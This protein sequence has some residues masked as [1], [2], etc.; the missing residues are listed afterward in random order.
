MIGG[1]VRVVTMTVVSAILVSGAFLGGFATSRQ[2]SPPVPR[3][4]GGAPTD[5]KPYFPV[6]WEA[7]NYVQQD[8][9]KPN[10]DNTALVNGA[11]GGMVNALGDPHTAFVDAK[12]AAISQTDLQ[13]SFEGIG[14][15]VEMREGRLSIVAPI[16][17]SPADRVGLK[18]DD[19]ILQ[20]DDKIIQN[21][22]VTEAVSLIRGPKGTTVTLKIQRA[23]QPP[24]TVSIVRDIIRTS[25]VESRM[26]EGTTIAYVRLNDFGA[27]APEELRTALKTLLAQHPTGLILDLRQDPGGYLDA[28]VD[29]ASQFLKDGQTVLIEKSKDGTARELKAKGGGLATNIPMVLLIDKG[30]ASASEIVAGALKDYKRATLIGVRSY[31]KGSVQNVHSLSDKSELRLTIAHFFSPMNNEINEVG[32]SPDIEVKITDDD[33][34]AKRDLQLDKAIEFLRTQTGGT[35][36]LI[37]LP[38]FAEYLAVAA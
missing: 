28:A 21:M 2:V 25:F 14:A 20:V 1:I 13:G 26:I 11:V 24:F 27:T 16:K 23:K 33:V 10:I 38:Q 36:Q 5:W 7:W 4:D 29:V 9:Y 34:A 31:G 19:I 12:R 15:T 37:P 17:G 30:S 8:F 32:V 3:P 18:P 6:F 35:S 22:D